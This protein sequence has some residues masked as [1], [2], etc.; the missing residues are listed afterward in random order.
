MSKKFFTG[1]IVAIAANLRLA[2]TAVPPIFT[3]I[4]HGL[5]VTATFTSLL[6]TIPLLCFAFGAMLTPKILSTIGLNRFMILAIIMLI[7]ANIIRPLGSS[8]M[9]MGTILVGLTIAFL[10]VL[11]PTII[12]TYQPQAVTTLTSYFSLT[13]GAFSAL[14][15]ALAVPL[16][17]L[18]GWRLFVQL[19]AIPAIIALGYWLVAHRKLANESSDYTQ[20]NHDKSKNVSFLYTFCHDRYAWLLALFMGMQS[21]VFYSLSTWLPTM[22]NESGASL[23]NAGLMLSLF[24]LIG[25]PAAL[26]VNFILNKKIILIIILT[27]YLGGIA[28]IMVG[29]GALW[30]S[31][32][33]L[34]FASS[35]IF[36]FAMT[37]IATS[38]NNP[39]LIAMR[40][41]F[42]Q[43]IG[44]LIA[45]IGPMMFGQIA[46]HTHNVLVMNLA[47]IAVMLI[48]ISLG[49]VAVTHKTK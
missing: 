3:E 32:L 36:T 9:L 40:S 7:I 38:G 19:I 18:I 22:Y 21:F 34:G 27:G 45:A 15:I 46:S 2:I 31:A 35:L 26:L 5:H 13:M 25:I 29:N 49:F 28:S 33:L 37:L 23:I 11:V 4:Q 17:R 43:F 44:Y 47:F 12:A 39:Q 10:N 1:L 8:T 48:T 24:Q 16:T 41:G 30:L 6:V 14:G 20:S 42:A